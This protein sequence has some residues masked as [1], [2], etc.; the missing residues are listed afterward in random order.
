MA[1][2]SISGLGRGD[3]P[4]GDQA[5]RQGAKCV[6]SPELK[7][8]ERELSAAAVQLTMSERLTSVTV[9]DRGGPG[10]V[11]EAR[12]VSAAVDA[13]GGADAGAVDRLLDSSTGHPM[14]DG[15]DPTAW[16]EFLARVRTELASRTVPPAS[17]VV[18][19]SPATPDVLSAEQRPSAAAIAAREARST[20]RRD[21]GSNPRPGPGFALASTFSPVVRALRGRRRPGARLLIAA[22]LATAAVATAAAIAAVSVWRGEERC[23]TGTDCTVAAVATEPPSSVTT[24]PT[25]TAAGDGTTAT[26]TAEVTTTVAP[27]AATTDQ[28]TTT[29]GPTTSDLGDATTAPPAESQTATSEAGS[30]ITGSSTTAA[31]SSTSAVTRP[32]PSP[33]TPR[34]TTT[35]PTTTR[36]TTTTTRP[37]TTRPPTT[38]TR[39]TT[40]TT[41]PPT[42]TTTTR[43][44]TT[45]TQIPVGAGVPCPAGAR[46]TDFLAVTGVAAGDVLNVR[47]G[48]GTSFA[49]V[50]GLGPTQTGI[51]VFNDNRDGRWVMIVIPGISTTDPPPNGCGWVHTAYLN[52]PS[53]PVGG[54]GT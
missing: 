49:V 19:R 3:G 26:T 41:R 38:T 24:A 22:A 18:P 23:D 35:R 11:S 53:V 7:Q 21:D 46:P 44:T 52:N 51:P 16:G 45:T 37:T 48:P 34:S 42:T 8:L 47:R 40:T 54:P 39:P 36:P 12:V 25:T 30:T 13:L 2:E 17:P 4:E 43:P 28:P 20:L 5:P 29:A 33:T 14:L 31:P 32:D 50:A 10:D 15:P 27:E 6:T 1:L 9:V